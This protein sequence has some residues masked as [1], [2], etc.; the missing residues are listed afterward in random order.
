MD[1][2]SIHVYDIRFEVLVHD[3]SYSIDL[4]L[5]IFLLFLIH[6]PYV[7]DLDT[8]VHQLISILIMIF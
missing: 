6:L 4:I 2:Y 3:I 1:V 7:T 5:M 8:V